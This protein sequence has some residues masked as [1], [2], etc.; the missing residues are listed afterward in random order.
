VD[1][2]GEATFEGV[3]AFDRTVIDGG[4][5]GVAGVVQRIGR[6]LRH[7]QTGFV[8]SYALGVAAGVVV[9]LG[10]FVSRINF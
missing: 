5:V 4:A 7:I 2:P 10:Y 1:G 8:R 9:L 3:A 6:G